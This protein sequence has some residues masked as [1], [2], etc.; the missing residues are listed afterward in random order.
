[1]QNFDIFY[2]DNDM[3][4]Y[5][6]FS[7]RF[8]ME[9]PNIR[10]I[11]SILGH[12]NPFIFSVND[13]GMKLKISNEDLKKSINHLINISAV[14]IQNEKLA[15]AFPF[16]TSNDCKT[17]KKIVLQK[18]EEIE[19]SFE[20][21]M[22]LFRKKIGDLYP[23]I[24]Q[25]LSLYHL[26]CGKVFDGTMFDFLEKQNL[27]RQSF[28]Q[29]DNR[30]Y[31]IIGYEDNRYCKK[32]NSELFC[33]FNHARYEK[34]SLSSFGNAAGNRFDYF[35][36]FRLREKRGLYGKFLKVDKDLKIYSSDE[37][38][39]RSLCVLDSLYYKKP[40]EKDLFYFSLKRFNYINRDD[41][42]IV[43]VFYN[44]IEK[45]AEF[46][47]F[48]IREVGNTIV[49]NMQEVR[50]EVLKSD[51]SCIKHTVPIEQLC[52]ELWHIYFGLLNKFLVDKRYV[53]T[54]K[55]FIGE[56]KYLKCVYI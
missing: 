38:V 6:E 3:G 21:K 2:F 35:R 20:N 19:K 26:L 28:P 14:N 52:N 9:Q 33:S 13:L 50:E 45:C 10:E 55:H 53:A 48:V 41:Q 16:F 25:S 4:E 17:I 11:I 18:L 44:H 22:A 49:Q 32:F 29:K 54:P 7:P 23:D 34:S 31:M 56:G 43:P 51:I 24:D 27:L 47:E 40:F 37:I 36:Y 15:L 1:M 12:N 42:I 5:N 8:V 39:K 46:S 30:D